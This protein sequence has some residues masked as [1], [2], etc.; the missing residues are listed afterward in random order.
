[1]EWMTDY[2]NPCQKVWYPPLYDLDVGTRERTACRN[3]PSAKNLKPISCL[4]YVYVAGVEKS[5]TTNIYA[6]LLK[7]SHIHSTKK[8]VEF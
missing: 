5:G 6:S 3:T 8:E 2:R 7:H 1:M 4:P